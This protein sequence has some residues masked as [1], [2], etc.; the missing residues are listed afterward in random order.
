MPESAPASATDVPKPEAG[1]IPGLPDP[2]PPPASTNALGNTTPT[3]PATPV[4]SLTKETGTVGSTGAKVSS[5]MSDISSGN[6]NA[7][8]TMITLLIIGWVGFG[9]AGFVMSLWCLGFS[10]NVGQKIGGMFFALLL[11]PFYWAYFYSVP[12]YCARLPPPSTLF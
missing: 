4:Q 9:F 11:G 12:A 7:E 3:T 10:G 1:N 2:N 5:F 8:N 6:L